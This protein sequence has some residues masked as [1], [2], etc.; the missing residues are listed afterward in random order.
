MVGFA[1][2]LVGLAVMTLFK[3]FF[4][5]RKEKTISIF[6]CFLFRKVLFFSFS[7]FCNTIYVGRL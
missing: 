5:K 1:A 6:V 4:K 3:L 2:G 7:V